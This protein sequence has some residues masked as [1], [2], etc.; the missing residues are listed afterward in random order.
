M[1]FRLQTTLALG[2]ITSLSTSGCD[3]KKDFASDVP[4]A[5]ANSDI[6]SG[7]SGTDVLGGG[8]GGA[9]GNSTTVGG[10]TSNGP[11]FSDCNNFPQNKYVAK[12]Y[13]IDDNARSDF[14][15]AKFGYANPVQQVC[16]N[17]LDVPVREFKE[18][19]PGLEE[20][21]EW[22]V[23]DIKFKLNVEKA[24]LYKF[25]MDSDDGSI[26]T[27]DGKEVINVDGFRDGRLHQIKEGSIELSAGV[28]DVRVQ[29]FQGPFF[30]IALQLK[31]Q[32]PATSAFVVIPT[33]LVNR[34]EDL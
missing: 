6:G 12:V 18:G 1:K 8:G 17:E 22:F 4:Q 25:S 16:L 13:K 33:A 32:P 5:S 11:L 19:F 20:F 15:L 23:L 9:G 28:H 10:E 21:I 26:T 3:G 2:L 27:I 14:K 30:N 24:G 34:P 29:Y 31:W 7:K